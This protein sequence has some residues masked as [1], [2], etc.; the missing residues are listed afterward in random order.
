VIFFVEVLARRAGFHRKQLLQLA[1][2][3][4]FLSVQ[5]HTLLEGDLWRELAVHAN[6]LATRLGEGL[7]GL[8][9]A[10][11]TPP[12]E[13]TAVFAALRVAAIAPL[14]AHPH[15]HRWD[16]ARSIA[17][18]MTSWDTMPADVDAFLAAAADTL[19]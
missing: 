19:S 1:S 16:P 10:A 4:R 14:Q 5:L 17:R 11:L 13:T 2:K 7:G 3:M 18:L 15:F 8:P 6:A 12:V 9:G